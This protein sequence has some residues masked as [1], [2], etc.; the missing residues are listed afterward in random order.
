M[1]NFGE[2]LKKYRKERKLTLEELADGINEKYGEYGAK[3]SKGML[4]KYEKG[5]DTNIRNANFIAGFFGIKLDD[6]IGMDLVAEETATY[7]VNGEIPIIGT[8]AA[9]TPILAE[10]NIL[11]Y[12]PAPP[13][14]KL[15]GR[16]VFY[17]QIKGESMNR[18]FENG[19]FV[20][21]D[22][23]K[24]VENGEI[25][26]VMVN[27]HEATV[28]KIHCQDNLVTLI[29]MSNDD[30]FYPEIINLET[31]EFTIIGKVIGAFKQY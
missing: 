7:S 10:Q 17:L 24:Q 8:I 12:A 23:D 25:A 29:P 1:N 13:L 5:T 30:S 26:A 3:L 2:N 28:K 6:L 16:N 21:I 31:T 11:G 14:M 20:L 15:E 27:G 22:R 19:S 9:G 18:E 4:S